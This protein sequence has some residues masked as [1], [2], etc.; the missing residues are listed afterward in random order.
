[1]DEINAS[2]ASSLTPWALC[3]TALLGP[4]LLVWAVRLAALFSGCT[5][6]PD[7]CHGIPF[8]AGLRDA[9]A[10]NWVITTSSLLLI[11]LS[12]AAMLFAFRICRPLLGT[13]TML[14]MPILA[15]ILPILA[16]LA[17]RY[18]DCA[19]SNDAIGSC[20][21]WGAAMGMSF[22]NAAIARDVVYAIVPYSFALAAM[23]GVLGFCFAR[24]KAPP[25]LQA[26]AKMRQQVG[27]D[28]RF[29]E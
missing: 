6:G 28:Q 15:P 3:V 22:H 25:E 14:V 16:V 9:L 8:G 4:A 10:L 20:Q 23:L 17:S 5:P 26:M 11:G 27:D 18:P 24:P 21:L 1:M 7:I 12:L 19:V 13:L 2:R 29:E